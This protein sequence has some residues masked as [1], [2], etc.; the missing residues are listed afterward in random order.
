MSPPP[1]VKKVD[2]GWNDPPVLKYSSSNPPPKS[3]ITNKRVAFPLSSNQSST[4]PLLPQSQL[5]PSSNSNMIP[6]SIQQL[7]VDEV[8]SE[9]HIDADNA[10][11]EILSNAQAALNSFDDLDEIQTKINLF[12]SMWNENKFSKKLQR[13]VLD[14]TR[15]I[16]EGN[17]EKANGCVLQLIMEDASLCEGWI[18]AFKQLITLSENATK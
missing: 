18:A 14:M 13:Y 9:Q 15:H 2:P 11:K 12:R 1:T 5:P 4:I 6:P 17:T 7:S 3:R 8:E 10:L 16:V